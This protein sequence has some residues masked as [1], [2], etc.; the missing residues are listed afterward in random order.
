MARLLCPLLMPRQAVPCSSSPSPFFFPS[1]SI[2]QQLLHLLCSCPVLP[3]LALIDEEQQRG[4]ADVA[5]G[6]TGSEKGV[7]G[8]KWQT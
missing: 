8:G 5:F 3:V 1:E 7:M 6:F 4:P 2:K